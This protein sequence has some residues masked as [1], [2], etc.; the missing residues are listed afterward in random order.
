M[1]GAHTPSFTRKMNNVESLIPSPLPSIDDMTFQEYWFNQFPWQ[2][3]GSK[4]M[5]IKTGEKNEK[6]FYKDQ[7][8][9]ESLLPRDTVLD[10]RKS[11]DQLL[12]FQEVSCVFRNFQKKV[13]ILKLSHAV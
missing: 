5:R 10:K 7:I 8:D 1:Y 6:E 4:R 12:C 2:S 13:P 3:H 11:T 9:P